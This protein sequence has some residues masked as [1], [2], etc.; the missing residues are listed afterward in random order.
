M[1]P[2]VCFSIP[3]IALGSSDYSGVRKFVLAVDLLEAFL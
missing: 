2:L 3:N 1:T